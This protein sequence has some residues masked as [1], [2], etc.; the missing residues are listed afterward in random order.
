MFKSWNLCVLFGLA[1]P[2]H[3][4]LAELLGLLEGLVAPR[5]GDQVI[6]FVIGFAE[7]QGNR[8]ELRGG[9]ALEEEDGIFG[10]DV[11]E[12]SEVR[13]GLLDYGGEFFA[14]VAHFHDAHARSAPVVELRLGLLEDVLGQIGGPGGEV[15]DPIL[16]FRRV[17]AAILD[18]GRGGRAFDGDG[19]GVGGGGDS[20]GGHGDGG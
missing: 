13:L 19:L 20:G 7:I 15:E 17:R 6:D 12:G 8:C 2:D 10:R 14:T 11:Q 4:R 9:P 5:S 16:R 3:L 18:G 1:G